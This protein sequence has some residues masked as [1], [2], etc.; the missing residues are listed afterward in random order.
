MDATV[1][2]EAKNNVLTFLIDGNVVCTTTNNQFPYGGQVGIW[3]YNTQIE[4]STFD[5]VAL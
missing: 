3:A 1:K 2:F 4:V 5:V